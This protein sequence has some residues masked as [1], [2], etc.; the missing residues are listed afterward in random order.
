MRV[1]R[2]STF[3]VGALAIAFGLLAQGVN[4]AVLV[5][6]AI[7]VAASAN[8]P[9]LA[10]SLFWRRFNTW[11]VIGGVTAGLVSSLV[12]AMTG[13]AFLAADATSR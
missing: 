13:P 3:A 8:F 6:L 1:A 2:I 7:N 4:V 9:M 12:L 10:L 11:G 5:V